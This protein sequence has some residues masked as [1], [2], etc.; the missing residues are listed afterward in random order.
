MLNSNDVFDFQGYLSQFK[1]CPSTYEFMEKLAYTQSFSNFIEE[2][3]KLECL[4]KDEEE[5]LTNDDQQL[6]LDKKKSVV[7]T[8]IG[9][10][11][12][13]LEIM[14]EH[15]FKRLKK[16]QNRMIEHLLLKLYNVSYSN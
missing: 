10:F 6:L 1:S 15:N 14:L 11:K 2:T 16:E 9:F 7:Q 5:G 13:N 8:Q 12:V 4:E 3:Y